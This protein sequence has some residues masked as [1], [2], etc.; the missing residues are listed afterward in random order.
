MGSLGRA[1]C[2]VHWISAQT[3]RKESK[4]NSKLK[5]TVLIVYTVTSGKS[6]QQELVEAEKKENFSLTLSTIGMYLSFFLFKYRGVT[7]IS[8]LSY[9]WLRP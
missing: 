7:I 6:L 1:T 4:V 5:S 3:R 2:T 9:L 8:Y